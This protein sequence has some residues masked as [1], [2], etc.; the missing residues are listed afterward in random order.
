MIDSWIRENP[1]DLKRVMALTTC[2][3]MSSLA[4]GQLI[5]SQHTGRSKKK[6]RVEKKVKAKLKIG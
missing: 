4:I 1:C 5:V 2:D 3:G 6:K